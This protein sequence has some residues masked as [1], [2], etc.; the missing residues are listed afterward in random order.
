MLPNVVVSFPPPT[1][2]VFEE[3]GSPSNDVQP[4][5]SG[6]P[7]PREITKEGWYS[8]LLLC[9]KVSFL[10][11]FSQSIR[12]RMWFVCFC[13]C[14]SFLGLVV[15][16]LDV[17]HALQL[18]KILSIFIKRNVPH[19]FS[20]SASFLGRD[21]IIFVFVSS[22]I[23]GLNLT[24]ILNLPFVLDCLPP[25]ARTFWSPP[26]VAWKY[27]KTFGQ[28]FLS[29]GV[30]GRSICASQVNK[31]I[32]S[33]CA[34]FHFP[35]F[36]DS[37]RGHVI[38]TNL[39]ILSR[40]SPI[41]LFFVGTKFKSGFLS[42]LSIEEAID[43]VL[44]KFVI[45]QEELLGVQGIL[46]EWKAKVLLLVQK[47]TPASFVVQTFFDFSL[48]VPLGGLDHLKILQWSF[49]IIYMDKCCNNFGFVCKKF[50]VSSFFSEFNSPIGAYVVSN[51]A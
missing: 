12:P 43:K 21:L 41:E 23:D 33:S 13:C 32:H 34:F 5:H 11:F 1:L 36:V 16:N 15:L 28:E 45:K 30:L 35:S 48:F 49:V 51:H 42:M 37:H 44:K 3:T 47:R 9:L 46:N 29:Y 14:L 38:S 50:Y 7:H 4:N 26:L 25:F 6:V 22:H 40:P 24:S 19:S 31:I 18:F 2:L 27:I 39:N 8:F 17:G 10:L 20:S